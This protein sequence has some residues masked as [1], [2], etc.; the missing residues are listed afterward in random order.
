MIVQEQDEPALSVPVQAA[1]ALQLA[2]AAAGFLVGGV[3]AENRLVFSLCRVLLIPPGEGFGAT[4]A[5]LQV[6][7]ALR[8]HEIA[9]AERL[10]EPM[11]AAQ[12]QGVSQPGPLLVITGQSGGQRLAE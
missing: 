6:V 1:P 5:R 9:L 2:Q 12:R 8:E 10:A 3:Q 4:Q 7:R 11:P